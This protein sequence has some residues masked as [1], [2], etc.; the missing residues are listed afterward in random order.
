MPVRMEEECE[1]HALGTVVPV[2]ERVLVRHRHE[3]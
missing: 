3:I 2:V 1:P